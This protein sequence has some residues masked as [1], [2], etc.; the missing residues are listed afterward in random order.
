ME[1]SPVQ[2][3]PV[4]HIKTCPICIFHHHIQNNKDLSPLP[5]YVSRLTTERYIR[6]WVR[7]VFLGVGHHLYI[8]T[9]VIDIAIYNCQIWS[10]LQ[11]CFWFKSSPK[12]SA[13]CDYHYRW[14]LVTVKAWVTNLPTPRA[15]I[16]TPHLLLNG[17]SITPKDQTIINLKYGLFLLKQAS[18]RYFFCVYTILDW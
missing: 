5:D 2:S 17:A 6:H 16:R 10:I 7:L 11:C 13:R 14:D 4:P 8:M 9:L 3:H 1:H 18:C 15:M 12:I